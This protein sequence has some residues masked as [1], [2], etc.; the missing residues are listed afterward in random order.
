MQSTALRRC[1]RVPLAAV[2]ASALSLSAIGCVERPFTPID[3]GWKRGDCACAAPVETL[4]APV[5][6][7]VSAEPRP[8]TRLMQTVSLGYAGDGPLTQIEPRREWWGDRERDSEAYGGYGYGYGGRG[9]AG[10]AG[11]AP[12]AAPRG[13]ASPT[14]HQ[15]MAT[16]GGGGAAA[17]TSRSPGRG[18]R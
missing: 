13:F 5:E 2:L 3:V 8:G 11:H 1:T 4:A 12:Q 7:A 14:L 16:R 17:A 18:P 6:V 15:G 10:H 9:R